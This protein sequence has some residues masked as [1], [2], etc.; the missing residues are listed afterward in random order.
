MI[1]RYITGWTPTPREIALCGSVGH[2]NTLS[3]SR[4]AVWERAVEQRV[5]AWLAA[6]IIAAINDTRRDQGVGSP[7]PQ[8][9]RD[10]RNMLPRFLR[11][12]AGLA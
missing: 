8:R 9:R 1:D 11:V 10:I 12:N 3:S 4:L 2:A 5:P 7:T 6:P